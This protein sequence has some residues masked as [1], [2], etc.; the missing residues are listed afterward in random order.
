MHLPRGLVK[1]NMPRLRALADFPVS[2]PNRGS[3]M[4][5][6]SSCSE[7]ASGC[8]ITRRGDG[9]YSRDVHFL[10]GERQCPIGK[11][12]SFPLG[13]S[14][15][16]VASSLTHSLFRACTSTEIIFFILPSASCHSM[17]AISCLGSDSVGEVF[18]SPRLGSAP[19]TPR[20]A[21]HQ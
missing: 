2:A 1:S 21:M 19:G 13:V 9:H 17:R 7:K 14:P 8:L 10:D 11:V 18:H 15:S 12:P 5:S 20:T 6:R 4:Q 3:S 16:G